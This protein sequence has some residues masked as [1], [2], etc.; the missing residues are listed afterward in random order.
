MPPKGGALEP[1]QIATLEA[2]IAQGATW[3]TSE[4]EHWHW[5]YRPP[6]RPNPPEVKDTYWPRNPIDHFVLSTLESQNLKPS[7]ET[8]KETLL[9]RVTLDLTGLRP[10]SPRSMIS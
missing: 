1:Q 10:Q 7:P 9:R 6:V 5:A 3:N 2:W 8:D 4:G